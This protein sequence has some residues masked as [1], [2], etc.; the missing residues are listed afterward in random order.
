[1]DFEFRCN[2]LHSLVCRRSDPEFLSTL[3]A[4]RQIASN[5]HYHMDPETFFFRSK[6]IL[7]SLILTSE[8]DF[9]I[10]YV[11]LRE[12]EDCLSITI[13]S[14]IPL[15]GR[16]TQL[17]FMTRRLEPTRCA[18]PTNV[19]VVQRLLS[20]LK[21]PDYLTFYETITCEG[22]RRIPDAFDLMNE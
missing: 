22:S 5:R 9:K 6:P 10:D 1:M 11:W 16:T 7:N 17:L 3:F 14:C 8:F 19:R 15:E 20:W 2:A 12:C 18:T 4:S 13:S 21:Y